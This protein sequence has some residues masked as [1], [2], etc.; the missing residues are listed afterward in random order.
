M[1]ICTIYKWS[2]RGRGVSG[3]TDWVW[4][5]AD[6]RT[7]LIEDG[8]ALMGR[9]GNVHGKTVQAEI[10]SDRIGT[11]LISFDSME[12]GAHMGMRFANC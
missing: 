7:R 11:V 10:D 12:F 4:Q 1:P 2:G 3:N 5:G 8:N 6:W 9:T